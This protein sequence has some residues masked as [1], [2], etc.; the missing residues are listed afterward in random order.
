MTYVG[1]ATTLIELDGVTL[2]TD[3][4]LRNRLGHV[5]R[6]A[7]PVSDL[8][9]VDAVLISHAHRDHLDVPSLRRVPRDVPVAAPAAVG[10]T[11][12]R[13]GWTVT[14]LAPGERMRVGPVEV[15]GVPADHDGRRTPVGA[16]RDAIGFLIAGSLR[17][18]FAGDTDVFEGMRTI[19]DAL[20]T[21]LLP[22]WGWGPR[23]GTGHMGPDDAARAAA[24]LRPGTAIPIHWG[25]YASP[26]V[27]WGADPELPARRFASAVAARAPGVAVPIVAP[28]ESVDLRSRPSGIA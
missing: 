16:Q 2:L 26:R 6:I 22:V 14:E 7:A 25:T 24:L 27:W 10:D 19:D 15:S 20:D 21:A 8:P 5:R 4:L 17:I 1:H 9:H 18:Y 3:P 12:A 11:L 28:G 23:L 13:E